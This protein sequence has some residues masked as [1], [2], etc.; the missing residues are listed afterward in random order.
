MLTEDSSPYCNSS[1]NR[2]TVSD[3]LKYQL[4]QHGA[5]MLETNCANENPFGETNSC[6][7]SPELTGALSKL[8]ANYVVQQSPNLTFAM[9][10]VEGIKKIHVMTVQL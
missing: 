2:R 9:G 8:L 3:E 6:S 10:Q 4:H 5:E 7:G 1:D